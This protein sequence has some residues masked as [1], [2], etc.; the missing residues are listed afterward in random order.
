MKE[1]FKEI[2]RPVKGFEGLYEVS[3][4]GNVRSLDRTITEKNT[5]RKKL[6]KGKHLKLI[7][8]S[9]NYYMVHFYKNGKSYTKMVHRY[10]A[11]AF[12]E[13]CGEWFEGCEVDHINTNSLDNRA[14]NLKVCTSKENHNN[15][16]TRINNSNAKKGNI[17][18]N[19]G[20][21]G[22]KR[23]RA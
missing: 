8:N 16:L 6:I 17:P 2:W 9:H 10:V 22:W 1:L 7:N 3:D 4:L 18:W 11:Q 20:L 13:I 21:Y 14:V 12:P 23:K 5:L 19:K 15:P